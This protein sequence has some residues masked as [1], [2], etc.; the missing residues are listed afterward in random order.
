V[1]KNFFFAR[2]FRDLT[3]LGEELAT[4]HRE[5]NQERPCDATGEI[6]DVLRQRERR[7]LEQRPL[8]WT[9]SSCGCRRS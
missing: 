8:R 5:V 2:K 7:W 3:H 6:P 4:W 9:A 1:K